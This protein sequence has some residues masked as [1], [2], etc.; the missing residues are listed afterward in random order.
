M[1]MVCR[2]VRRYVGACVDG[3]LEPTMSLAIEQ[4]VTVC[5]GCREHADLH[6]ELKTH[7]RDA[8]RADKAPEALRARVT[9]V[10]GTMP[11]PARPGVRMLPLRYAIPIAAAA[12]V[13]ITTGALRSRISVAE[14]GVAPVLEDVV[15]GHQRGFPAEVKETEG[16]EIARSAS[17]TR[18]SA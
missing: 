18:M 11:M 5:K 12:V 2:D 3:E 1:T 8:V 15:R 17:R 9:E 7:V 10:L 13:A 16:E 4:H 6:R 14:A